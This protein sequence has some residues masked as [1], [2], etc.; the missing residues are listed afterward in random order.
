MTYHGRAR[1]TRRHRAAC[2]T[3]RHDR[4]H[5]FAYSR[6]SWKAAA[7]PA[8]IT[9]CDHQFQ[10]VRWRHRHAVLRAA[11]RGPGRG[12]QTGQWV[13]G[14]RLQPPFRSAD[15]RAALFHRPWPLGSPGHG[16]EPLHPR[17]PGG[18]AVPSVQ[19][20][21]DGAWLRLRRQHCARRGADAGPPQ[22]DLQYVKT[23]ATRQ[24]VTHPT[25]S[26]ASTT[27]RR[28]AWRT[29]SLQ[30]RT[31]LAGTRWRNHGTSSQAMRS[32][33]TQTCPS[34]SATP[35]RGDGQPIDW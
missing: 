28:C 26:S 22:A 14:P 9:A 27:T 10:R 24:P 30:S 7:T 31:T 2:H 1:R 33:P 3:P 8:C 23:V 15:D 29:S 17:H 25:E 18:R 35:S 34:Q 11:W 20:R 32:P 16:D 13:D 21:Q 4:I 12:H 6:T 5:R 19:P